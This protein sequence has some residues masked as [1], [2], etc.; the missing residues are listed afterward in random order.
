[1]IAK[2]LL[3]Q[4]EE[5]F[6]NAVTAV[7]KNAKNGVESQS[8]NG[9]TET[10]NRRLTI[11]ALTNIKKE[12]GYVS[13]DNPKR[14]GATFKHFCGVNID[15]FTSRFE[16]A[17]KNETQISPAHRACYRSTQGTNPTLLRSYRQW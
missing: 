1:M 7:L 4:G 10:K 13:L 6:M 14:Y 9:S 3:K 12:K 17:L 16:H 8:I 2:T 11:C 5:I 15:Y